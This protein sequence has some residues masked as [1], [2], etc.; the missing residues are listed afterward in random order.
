MPKAAR[1]HFSRMRSCFQHHFTSGAVLPSSPAYE[2]APSGAVIVKTDGSAA[3][4]PLRLCLQ[5]VMDLRQPW[6]SPT[7]NVHIP[8]PIL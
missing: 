6:P 4:E 8:Y 3:L 1:A 2:V 5:D 7:T